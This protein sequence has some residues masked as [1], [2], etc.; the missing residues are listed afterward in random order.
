M[1]HQI[2]LA[3]ST[4]V[5]VNCGSSDEDS[6]YPA[7]C[8]DGTLESDLVESA[9]AGSAVVNGVVTVPSPP[10]VVGYTYLQLPKTDAASA[11]FQELMTA[12]NQSLAT[13][14][15]PLAFK[16]ATSAMCGTARTIAVFADVGKMFQFTASPAHAAAID[17]RH[18]VSRGGSHTSHTTV[19]EAGEPSFAKGT[20]VLAADG[21]GL[22]F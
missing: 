7:S 11:K 20:V 4:L 1:R 21:D 9:W 3:L 16:V 8:Q 18:T 17:A 10:Y 13:P 19:S 15:A 2:M 5:L 14:V 22:V 6:S 12:V